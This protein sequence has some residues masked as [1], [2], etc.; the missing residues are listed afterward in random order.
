MVY[1]FLYLSFFAVLFIFYKKIFP[2]LKNY[3]SAYQ[4]KIESCLE[5]LEKEHKEHSKELAKLNQDMNKLN[6]EIDD[7]MKQG[8][9]DIL[10][11]RKAYNVIINDILQEKRRIADQH[12]KNIQDRF[13]QDIHELIASNIRKDLIIWFHSQQSNNKLHRKIYEDSIKK[14]KS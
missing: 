2:Q 8:E 13:N 5:L 3:L 6:I 9:I 10:K 1:F 14:I 7:I 4:K 11:M 12:I